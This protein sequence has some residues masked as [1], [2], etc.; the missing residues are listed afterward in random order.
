MQLCRSLSRPT[1]SR[2][3][4][5]PGPGRVANE[6][7][8]LHIYVTLAYLSRRLC[9]AKSFRPT[10]SSPMPRARLW[11]TPQVGTRVGRGG[12]GAVPVPLARAAGPAQG[13]RRGHTRPSPWGRA[14]SI[15]F[16]QRGRARAALS[17]QPYA[18]Q[19]WEGGLAA[20]PLE[21]P[22]S[23]W[24]LHTFPAWAVRPLRATCWPR[25]RYRF[26]AEGKCKF[27]YVPRGCLELDTSG[28][29][30]PADIS[31]ENVR[32]YRILYC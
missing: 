26:L 4:A 21:I 32:S 23:A 3:R 27:H 17:F 6:S 15:S 8:F 31:K 19:H 22:A 10:S 1:S 25:G 18:P 11:L 29:T 14:V 30:H 12:W 16:P 24:L 13:Q 5:Q 2:E 9:G 7:L 28:A 20:M